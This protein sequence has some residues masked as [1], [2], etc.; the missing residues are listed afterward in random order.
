M[1]NGK[2]TPRSK[3]QRRLMYA[4]ANDPKVAQK[5]GVPTSVAREY[6]AG[7]RPGLDLADRV[8]LKKRLD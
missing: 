6:V 3:A 5:T 7:D 2:K 8:P 4:V 1:P